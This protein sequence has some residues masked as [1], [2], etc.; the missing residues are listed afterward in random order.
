MTALTEADFAAARAQGDMA[1]LALMAAGMP[2]A[3]APRQRARATVPMP[4]RARPGA[5]P[6]GARRPGLTQETADFLNR[7][8]PGRFD[9]GD[10]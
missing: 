10:L 4:S 9:L 5:W 3:A 8:W 1:A 2:V 7:L 6:D